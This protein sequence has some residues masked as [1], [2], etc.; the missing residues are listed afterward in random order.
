MQRKRLGVAT[1]RVETMG[2]KSFWPEDV[3]RGSRIGIEP[4]KVASECLRRADSNDV[5]P[6]SI[7][8]LLGALQT[9]LY[10]LHFVWYSHIGE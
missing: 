10:C 6:V 7:A 5:V 4:Q 1:Q 8:S 3:E 9:L 2:A